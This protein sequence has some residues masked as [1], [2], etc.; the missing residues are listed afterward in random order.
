MRYSQV[1]A[2]PG[3]EAARQVL[4]Q[5]KRVVIVTKFRF[6]GDT[7]VATPF[8]HQLRQH[9]PQ[10]QITQLTAPSVV[11]ALAHC[12]H[13]DRMQSLEM[14]GVG[15]LR[16]S[17][18]LVSELRKGQYEAVFLLNRSFHCALMCTLANIPVRIG[19]VNEFRRPL[20][21]VPI[22]YDFNRNEVDCHLDM[23]RAIGLEAREALP[24]LWLTEEE[25]AC[26]RT[27]LE[28]QAGE[29]FLR[30]PLIAIQ[31]G[32]NDPG[33][34]EWGAKRYAEVADALVEQTGGTV[35]LMGGESERATALETEQAMRHR[36]LNLAGALKLREALGVIGQFD[37]WLGNDTGLLHAAVAQRVPSVG[38]FGPN[39][40]V[41][42]GYATPRH[43]SLVV[44]PEKPAQDDAT[45]RRC[46][47]AITEEQVLETAYS[48]MSQPHKESDEPSATQRT[49]SAVTADSPY[50]GTPQTSTTLL[51]ARRR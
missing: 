21:T 25:Q 3:A 4:A 38:L 5:A 33:I 34:R 45:V 1:V 17:C 9:L 15:R 26:A 42:W 31:P 46:L 39:K 35:I 48:V 12:P 32:A 44:F 37:L 50:F 43:R 29:A 18:E 36:P 2:S 23:L 28:R 24:D 30:R 14:R 40:V 7:I 20:L 22:P 13:L 10:A 49:A 51:P 6:R 27:F 41:R 8:M 19:Y 47:D 16:H 11:T